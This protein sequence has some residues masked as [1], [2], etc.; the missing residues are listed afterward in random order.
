[1]ENCLRAH[2]DPVIPVGRLSR[3]IPDS[4]QSQEAIY[5]IFEAVFTKHG[6]L[7]GS[8]FAGSKA[9]VPVS[10]K[11]K[12]P[13]VYQYPVGVILK[14]CHVYFHQRFFSRLKQL[15]NLF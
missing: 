3:L 8:F 4:S 11:C 7:S 2:F 12:N 6:T 5:A 15:V 1:M 9:E 13:S 10:P 14:A